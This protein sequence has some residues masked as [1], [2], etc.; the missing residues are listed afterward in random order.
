MKSFYLNTPMECLEYL[1]M[2]LRLIPQLFIDDI[3]LQCKT[4]DRFVYMEI[5]KAYMYYHML[6]RVR[7]GVRVT[8]VKSEWHFSIASDCLFVKLL[9]KIQ[10]CDDI[11]LSTDSQSIQDGGVDVLLDVYLYVIFLNHYWHVL[12][13]NLMQLWKFY[14]HWSTSSKFFWVDGW[15]IP[16]NDHFSM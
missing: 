2:P 5:R 16:S 7:V 4:K 14:I 12:C 6:V 11:F 3:Y 8:Y 10:E 13:Y 1:P 15:D 9:S